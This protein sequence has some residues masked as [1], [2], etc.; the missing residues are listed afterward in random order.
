VKAVSKKEQEELH[1][2]EV[3]QE[4]A[5]ESV[6][7]DES[8]V[9][10]DDALEQ[11][12]KQLEQKEDRLLRLQAEYDNFR[13]RTKQEKESAAKYRSEKLAENLLPAM[14]NFDRALMT[15]PESEEAKSLLQGMKMI[16]NQLNEALNTEEITVMETVGETFDPTKHEAVM[17]VESEEFESN[18]VVEELQKGY[19]LK[20]KVLRPAMV[21]VNA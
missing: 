14:D 4:E 5:A 19:M 20:D 1:E 7:T 18:V 21:K 8:A 17:Q 2:E 3:Q 6:Q 16:Y 11:L 10:E 12:E 9:E 13:R 15:E